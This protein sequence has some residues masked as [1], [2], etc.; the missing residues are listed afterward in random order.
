M[1]KNGKIFGKINIIDLAAI[2]IVILA[3]VGI[4]IRFTSIAAENVNQKTNFTYVVEIED[5]RMYSVN[6]LSKKGLATDKQGNVIGE[7][8]N[9]EYDKMIKQLVNE[10]GE[11]VKVTTPLRYVAKVTLNA[12]GKDTDSGYFV[13]EN[14]ELSVGSSITMYTKYS[15][16]SG[17]I[18]KVQKQENQG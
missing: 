11:Q 8:T 17:K 13:G 2:L 4:T 14:T 18:I 12:E 5:I 7:I 1:D 9:V 16:C 3:I 10:N 6:A 15:N